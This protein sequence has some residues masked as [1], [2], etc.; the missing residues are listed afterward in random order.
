[1]SSLSSCFRL[2]LAVF[3]ATLLGFAG[4]GSSQ[5]AQVSG[6]VHY[7]G[8][9]PIT[10]NI[11][12]IRFEPTPDSTAAIRKTA[13]S[14]IAPDGSF[15]LFTRKV[16]DGVYPGKYAVTFTVLSGATDGRILV[17]PKYT[18]VETTPYLVD[19]TGDMPGQQFE[20]EAK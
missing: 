16:G 6:H 20:I 18:S 9:A 8:G 11:R 1:M 4:C 3:A 13:S 19:V 10:G 5:T 12:V 2:A 14:E 7:K 15:T 17:D